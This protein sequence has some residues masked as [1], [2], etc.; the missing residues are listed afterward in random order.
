MFGACRNIARKDAREIQPDLGP[1][2]A[3]V[4]PRQQ[5]LHRVL[6]RN[7]LHIGLVEFLQRRIQ[8]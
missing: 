8:A 4:D 1:H 7:Y 2:L 6:R 5:I 3:L